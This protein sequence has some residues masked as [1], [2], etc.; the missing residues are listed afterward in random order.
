MRR[1]CRI[2]ILAVL[3][4]LSLP[5]CRNKFKEVRVTSFGVVSVI[6]TGLRSFDAV[7]SLG[8]DNPAPGFTL[9]EIE[10][11]VRRDSSA[12]FLLSVEDVPVQGHCAKDYQV[13]V[14][15]TLA[16]GV[17]LLQ[18]AVLLKSFDP[19]QYS[20]DVSARALLAGNIGKK[21]EYKDIPL[22]KFMKNL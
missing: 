4:L 16:E 20:V 3:V 12:V 11:T 6:P 13:P 10:G 18:M 17:T 5:S 9:R 19:A 14:H 22:T 15:G 21:L 8:V 2:L 7:V 1:K